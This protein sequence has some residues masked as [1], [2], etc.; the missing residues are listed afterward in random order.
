MIIGI[1]ALVVAGVLVKFKKFEAIAL[2]IVFFGAGVLA[3]AWTSNPLSGFSG[4][5]TQAVAFVLTLVLA[6][7]MWTKSREKWGFAVAFFAPFFGLSCGGFI[8]SLYDTVFSMNP[9][10]ALYTSAV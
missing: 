6:L 1:T 2:L 7:V 3:A 8:G 10:A 5:I 4:E 9:W